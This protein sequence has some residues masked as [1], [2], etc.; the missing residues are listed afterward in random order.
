MGRGGEGRVGRGGEDTYDSGWG[1]HLVLTHSRRCRFV[2][3]PPHFNEVA[4]EPLHGL[5]LTCITTTDWS[6][7]HRGLLIK[8]TYPQR[9]GTELARAAGRTA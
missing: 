5:L 8:G 7:P 1:P 4:P 9:R 6:H 2:C 3:S